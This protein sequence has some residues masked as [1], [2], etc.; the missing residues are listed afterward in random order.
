MTI[1]TTPNATIVMVSMTVSAMQEVAGSGAIATRVPTPS[2]RKETP[3]GHNCHANCVRTTRCVCGRG[4]SAQ[5]RERICHT[6]APP[7]RSMQRV[8]G[9]STSGTLIAFD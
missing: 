2:R 3:I 6:L 4:T 1:K 9:H 7:H 5:A 8:C